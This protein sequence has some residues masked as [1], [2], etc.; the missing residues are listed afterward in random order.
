MKHLRWTIIWAAGL[1]AL[2]AGWMEVFVFEREP[3]FPKTE[4]KSSSPP[5]AA[6]S[7]HGTT[8]TPAQEPSIYNT[9]PRWIWW[10]EQ[11]ARD[12]DFEWKSP[13]KFYGKVID[14]NNGAVPGAMVVFQWTDTSA[15][16]TSERTVYTG[17]DGRFELTGVSGK[18]LGINQLQKDGYYR[19]NKG[20]PRSFEYAAFF[21]ENY[22]QP[23]PANPVTFRLKKKGD[24]PLELVVRQA[25]MGITPD[26]S[27]HYIDLATTRKTSEGKGDIAIRITRTAPTEVKQYD[28]EA[29][30]EGVNGA[31]VLESADEFMFEAPEAGYEQTYSYRFRVSDPEWKS[32]LGRK[33]FVRARNGQLHGRLEL[34]FIPK[35]QNSAAIAV[36]FYVNPTGSRN[37]EYQPNEVLPR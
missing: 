26:G 14:E 7:Q 34:D 25:L 29:T 10:N 33:Y 18:R 35:Y 6:Q 4:P 30:I 32:Q 3:Q 19:V 24:V 28:W 1:L 8:V 22:Y 13:I 15:N 20:A 9:D 27:P 5:S 36:H 23:D 11:R 17:G 31:G 2:L 37:L 21:E 16:G 12:P